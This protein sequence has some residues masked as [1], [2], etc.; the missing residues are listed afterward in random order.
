MLKYKKD[1]KNWRTCMKKVCVLGAGSW[2][3]A[4]AMVLSENNRDVVLWT[5]CE[6][7]RDEINLN[8]TNERYLK[9]IK[10]PTNIKATTDIKEAVEGSKIIVLGVPSQAIRSVCGLIKPYIEDSQIIVNSAKGLEKE[11]GLRISEVVLEEIPGAN[12]VVLSGPSHAEEVAKKLPTVVT[13]SSV[14]SEFDIAKVVQDV[15]TAEYFRVYTNN[16]LIGVELG[17]T[18]KNIIALGCG[19]CDGLGYGDNTRSALITRGLHEMKSFGVYLGAK[20][21]TFNG[22]SGIG[23]LIAT[24]TSR[25]SR[26]S[27]AGYLIGQGYTKEEAIEKVEMV[28]EGITAIE[29]VYAKSRKINKEFPILNALYSIVFEGEKAE[30]VLMDLMNRSKKSE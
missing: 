14:E 8:R 25:H 6:K 2:G 26:N 9:N 28:V 18:I 24:C 30:K 20:E 4:L 27:R 17:G 1:N 21:D 7:Q 23:D 12:Y 11:T 19:I 10:I 22:L 3:T 5:R 13:V 16:D 15:F 29:S